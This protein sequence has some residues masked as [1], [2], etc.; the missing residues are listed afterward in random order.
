M[1]GTLKVLSSHHT[2][3][4]KEKKIYRNVD[5]HFSGLNGHRLKLSDGRAA[6]II[7]RSI[8][9]EAES[10]LIDADGYNEGREPEPIGDGYTP[11][12]LL[13]LRFYP[14]EA[15]NRQTD[16]RKNKPAQRKKANGTSSNI[17]QC[18]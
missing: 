6:I 17:N 18:R 14:N 13:E 1:I 15:T 4:L 16:R 12:I 11:S 7:I 5:I 10:F 9:I 2:F 3:F 8:T